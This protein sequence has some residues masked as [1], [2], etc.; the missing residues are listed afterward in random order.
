MAAKPALDPFANWRIWGDRAI[1]RFAHHG[2]HADLR[3]SIAFLT[4]LDPK[5]PDLKGVTVD[6]R[7]GLL[8]RLQAALHAANIKEV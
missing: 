2:D 8:A 6:Q 1:A 4:G 5:H 7:D 3:R